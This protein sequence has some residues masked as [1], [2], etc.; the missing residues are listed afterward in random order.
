MR[1]KT[2]RPRRGVQPKRLG[3][4]R[5]RLSTIPAWLPDRFKGSIHR[6]RRLSCPKR[7]SPWRPTLAMRVSACGKV[8]HDSSSCQATLAT[9]WARNPH[10]Y[11]SRKW[12]KRSIIRRQN[13][14]LRRSMRGN[15][16]PRRNRHTSF[17]LHQR[18][19]YPGDHDDLENFGREAGRARSAPRGLGTRVVLPF[20]IAR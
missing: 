3:L 4:K 16:S 13:F 8:N 12:D 20:S 17:T 5:A 1:L 10:W 7:S 15:G 6:L 2:L 19:H 11:D 9:V 18:V 14:K